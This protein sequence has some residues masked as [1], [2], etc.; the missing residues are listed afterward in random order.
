MRAAAEPAIRAGDH[1]LPADAPGVAL[2]P[3]RNELR[4]LDHIGRMGDHAGNKD[5]A[6][7]QFDR[8]PDRNLVLVP[9]I[10]AFDQIGL[11]LNLEHEIDDA[12]ELEIVG[13]PCQLP[14]HR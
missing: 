7:R 14:Q 8:V 3:L 10:G 2:Q 6:I 5:F 9:G 4:M 11:R 1:V 13:G 12:L